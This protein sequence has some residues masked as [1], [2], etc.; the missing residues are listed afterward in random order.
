AKDF[1]AAE[2]SFDLSSYPDLKDKPKAADLEDY[3]FPDTYFILADTSAT[4]AAQSI[5]KKSLDNFEQKFTPEMVQQA[6]KD[7]MSVF[8]I[9]TLASIVEKE[10]GNSQ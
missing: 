7:N 4:S 1:L 2:A 9:V 5:I 6:A 10:S 8:D 3:I